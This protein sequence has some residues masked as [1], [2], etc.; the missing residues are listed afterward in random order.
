MFSLKIIKKK[1]L[2]M[3]AFVKT[4]F[5]EVTKNATHVVH[6]PLSKSC[7]IIDTVLDFNF[8]SGKTGTLSA[9]KVI[10][11]ALKKKLTTEWILETHIHADHL[12]AAPYVQEKLGG[13]IGIGAGVVEV[14]E[15]FRKIYN[16][17]SE[18][19][20]DG[21]QFDRLFSDE[22]KFPLGNLEVRVIHTPG[23][24][25][26]CVTYVIGDTAFTGD[27]F[28]MP[29]LGTGRCDFPG[30]SAEQLYE[31]LVKI[32]SLPPNTR[33]FLNHDYGFQGKRKYGWETTVA[34]QREANIHIGGSKTAAE[35]V[36]MR[37]DRDSTLSVPNLILAA[38][39]V[40]MRAGRLPAAEDNGV[41]YLRIPLNVL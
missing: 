7:V 3:S 9:D 24:T 16:H 30:G 11:Y 6:D 13:K 41:R 25:P 18:L 1:Q 39:Q 35:F 27:T 12:T 28:L 8:S 31:S 32:L 37:N 4:F 22:E 34:E 5:D 36:A 33:L 17:G 14:Q 29:D 23:H 40:N 26:A 2:E 15:N 38:I 19:S 21:S 20:T 10:S